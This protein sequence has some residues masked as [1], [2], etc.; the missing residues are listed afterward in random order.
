MTGVV[1]DFGAGPGRETSC[2]PHNCQ[3]HIGDYFTE[4][5]YP[6]VLTYT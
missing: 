1:E 5:L 4:I 6:I 3:A 2:E